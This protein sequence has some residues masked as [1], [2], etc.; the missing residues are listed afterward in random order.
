MNRFVLKLSLC[1]IAPLTA[2]GTK[3]VWEHCSVVFSWSFKNEL[4]SFVWTVMYRL[5]A[6]SKWVTLPTKL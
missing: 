5:A 1:V 3:D 2:H 6:N 4:N